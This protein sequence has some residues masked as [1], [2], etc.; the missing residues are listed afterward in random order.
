MSHHKKADHLSPVTRMDEI[1]SSK[2]SLGIVLTISLFI[3]GAIVWAGFTQIDEV[4]IT[5]GEVIPVSK[6]YTIQHLEGGMIKN[7]LV[8]EGEEV[9]E[10]QV[11]VVF[12]PTVP[13]LEL[14]Q[15]KARNAAIINTAQELQRLLD[16]SLKNESVPNNATQATD[17][18]APIQKALEN[19]AAAESLKEAPKKP[20]NYPVESQFLT[21]SAFKK[22]AEEDIAQFN[23]LLEILTK[24]L[25]IM[26]QEKD[27]YEKLISQGVISKK[28]YLELLRVI[29]QVEEEINKA[30][31][32]HLE[33]QY[34]ISKLEQRL[35]NIEVKSPIHGVVKG[36]QA[37]ASNII[38]PGGF[39]M[40]I[41]PLENLVVEAR[42]KSSDIGLVKIGD[43]VRVKV[44]TYDFT[45]FGDIEGTL[46]KV[47][48]TT[49]LENPTNPQSRQ[50]TLG[51]SG[52]PT[53]SPQSSSAFYKGT[54]QLEKAYVGD[55]PEKNK[56][57]P[58]M[59][60]IADIHIGTKSLLKYLLKPVKTTVETSFREQ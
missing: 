8:K 16:I 46:V 59:T 53:P 35:N 21:F 42:I 18:F 39:L 15:I 47:S 29:T 4:V 27:M 31:E 3:I 45:R 57:V 22:E 58:G 44:D 11:L 7:I 32:A 12:D 36:L 56:L 10:G 43:K 41:V 2:L 60:V 30:Q 26:L 54:V 17:R 5:S 20:T 48:A 51:T 34:S 13:R 38:Q 9:Q 33:T 52:T 23:T 28:D 40:E 19:S 1:E 50:D 25:T 14:Q 24:R 37:H 6:I 49:F 55:D